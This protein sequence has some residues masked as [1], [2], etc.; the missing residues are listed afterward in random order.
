MELK[1]HSSLSGFHRCYYGSK[2]NLKRFKEPTGMSW[3]IMMP[4]WCRAFCWDLPFRCRG[5]IMWYLTGTLG[6]DN[7]GIS[8]I[9]RGNQIAVTHIRVRKIQYADQSAPE[10]NS[11]TTMACGLWGSQH[12]VTCDF[13]VL[14]KPVIT[15]TAGGC[16][17]I[18][19][20]QGEDLKAVGSSRGRKRGEVNQGD[21]MNFICF[22][23]ASAEGAV[24]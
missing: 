15:W 14:T 1:I 24:Q 8:G 2:R 19:W 3:F 16:S 11:S 22:S 20:Q 4:K 6:V 21:Q 23:E 12:H 10:V 5:T 17:D 9:W 7:A 13:T 18:S